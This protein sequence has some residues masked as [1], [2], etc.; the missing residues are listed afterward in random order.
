M[1]VL[2]GV[3]MLLLLNP[4]LTIPTITP[5]K[6]ISKLIFRISAVI[7]SL[8][9]IM[10]GGS[11]MANKVLRLE[12][13]KYFSECYTLSLTVTFLIV[14]AFPLSRWILKF[15]RTIG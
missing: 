7:L 4:V 5:T 12:H 11:W 2:A 13:L 15:G 10:F 8:P 3:D 6:A 9:A 1:G 14:V